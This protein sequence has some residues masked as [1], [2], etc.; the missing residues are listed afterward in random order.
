MH[1]TLQVARR[2]VRRLRQQ[3]TQL[4]LIVL[5]PLVLAALV[6]LVYP[7]H[8][9]RG[10]PVAV[11]DEDHSELS[12]ALGRLVASSPT[13]E[14]TMQLS[15]PKAVEEAVLAGQIEGAFQFPR[16]LQ[17]DVKR[18]RSASVVVY[19]NSANLI[20]GKLLLREGATLVGTASGGV[21]VRRL[22][23]QGLGED[24]ARALAQPIR[25]ESQTLFNPAANYENFLPPG[26]WMVMLQMT[27]MLSA[28]VVVN[29]EFRDGTFGELVRTA[30]GAWEAVLVGK[31]LPH[32][33]L[34]TAVGLAVVGGVMPLFGVPVRGSIVALSGFLLL[35]VGASFFM[36]LLASTLLRSP[37]KAAEVLVFY[38][39]PAFVF[40]GYT[41][42][43]AAMPALHRAY[44]QLMPFT[45]FLTGFIKLYQYGAPAA[46]VLPEAT[47]LF[48][49]FAVPAVGGTALA[50]RW[51]VRQTL[52]AHPATDVSPTH[53]PTT[54]PVAQTSEA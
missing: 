29:G 12:R 26:V 48:A 33:V 39:A 45:H 28:A 18:G 13:L 35:F 25:Y 38:T 31:A 40:S 51:R 36:A 44:A 37:V 9:V 46:T 50:M 27:V 30:D 54:E 1:P 21:L 10:L 16:G 20:T 15:S 42:P 32:L 43:I 4:A 23:A 53:A 47:V 2:E 7:K 5:A 22:R 6:G 52:D 34:Q 3:P 49:G 24:A 41:F 17:A 14:V 11:V 19:R 8:V